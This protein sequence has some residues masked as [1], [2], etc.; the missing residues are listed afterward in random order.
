LVS[1]RPE[2]NKPSA[3]RYPEAG[4]GYHARCPEAGVGYQ[5]PQGRRAATATAANRAVR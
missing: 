2:L 5:R 3:R 1:K 4:V